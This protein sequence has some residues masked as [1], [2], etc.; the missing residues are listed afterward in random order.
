MGIL[1]DFSENCICVNSRQ[2]IATDVITGAYPGFPTDLQPQICSL[3][4]IAYGE[5]KITEAV[6]A[7]RLGYLNELKKFG[8]CYTVNGNEAVIKGSNKYLPASVTATDL[9]GG[10][11]EVIC[12][13][14]ADGVS[15]INGVELIE[16]GYS[17]MPEKLRKLGANIIVV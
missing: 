17:N 5:S 2:P 1:I 13:L 12:A 14:N 6:F 8:L 9:R 11:A 7:N 4:G 3:C 15:V 16:R 10:A